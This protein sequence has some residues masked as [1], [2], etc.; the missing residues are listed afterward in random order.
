MQTTNLTKS[1]VRIISHPKEASILREHKRVG[2]T[3]GDHF[4]FN[5]KRSLDGE[6]GFTELKGF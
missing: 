4:D 5:I 3:S 6:F 2:F 1:S